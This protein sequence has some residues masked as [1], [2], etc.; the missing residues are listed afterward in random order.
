M[1]IQPTDRAL[2][3]G[4]VAAIVALTLWRFW[5][6]Q[7]SGIS[8]YVDEAYYWG[9]SQHLAWGYYSKPPLVAWLIW[10]STALFG[11]GVLGIKALAMLLYPATAGVLY[12]LG[13]DLFNAR[14][15]LV[16]ALLFCSSFMVGL[17]G[18]FVSTDALLVLCWALAAWCWWRA[19]HSTQLAWW[20]ACGVVLG[21]GLLSKYTLA[22][23][24][25]TALYSLWAHRT[26][27]VNG[28]NNQR[29]WRTPGPWLAAAVALALFA[30][31]LVWNWQNGMPT[32]RHTAEITASDIRPGG[33]SSL[34]E[35]WLGQLLMLGPLPLLVMLWLA[36]VLLRS[37]ATQTPALPLTSSASFASPHKP[38][39]VT[40]LLALALPLLVVTT[41]QS[42]RAQ[43]NLNWAAPS[44]VAVAVL[45]AAWACGVG[46]QLYG[47]TP[48]RPRHGWLVA[49]LAL[50]SLV[51]VLVCHAYDIAQLMG[52]PLPRNTDAFVRMRGWHE[53]LRSLKPLVAQHPGLPLLGIGRTLLAQTTYEWRSLGTQPVAWNPQRRADDQYQLTT[54]LERYKGQPVLLALLGPVPDNLPAH[55]E[56]M[57]LLGEVF[58]G[59]A[60]DRRLTVTLWR[61]NGFKGYGA[62]G[63]SLSGE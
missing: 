59:T 10:A 18:L 16:A 43:A 11:D 32:L 37:L 41:V 51:L 19:L 22:A 39:P 31:H 60:P 21:L 35:F 40:Y 23:F 45:F 62:T 44:Y 53:A 27:G 63:R 47:G 2:R 8:L 33:W 6:V 14:V 30:P 5:W 61:A 12:L 9:W 55:F 48:R 26:P 50:N 34:A 58:V 36:V 20:L 3:T 28:H 29:L 42:L 4:V 46:D 56:S 15:G 17:L 1:P 25:A 7:H 13:R 24:A 57:Q 49:T 38:H 52:R 54:D